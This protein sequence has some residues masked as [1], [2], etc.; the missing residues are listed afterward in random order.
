MKELA[1]LFCLL[2][3]IT[4]E[5]Q[6]NYNEGKLENT[7]SYGMPVFYVHANFKGASLSINCTE[8]EL[9]NIGWQDQISSLYIP[10][11]QGWKVVMYQDSHFND[12]HRNARVYIATSSIVN[13]DKI[14]FNDQVSSIKIY[15]YGVL[16][17]DCIW[18]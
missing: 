15:K 16:Q 12:T 10:Q 3:T 1:V 8:F 2:G 14:R 13:F 17:G 7:Q 5:T 11:N 18:K 4:F 6:T 9:R